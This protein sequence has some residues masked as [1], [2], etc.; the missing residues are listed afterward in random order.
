MHNVN[1]NEVVQYRLKFILDVVNDGLNFSI[2]A[3]IK[4]PPQMVHSRRVSTTQQVT[5]FVVSINIR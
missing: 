1:D 4:T 2:F 5:P 3:E